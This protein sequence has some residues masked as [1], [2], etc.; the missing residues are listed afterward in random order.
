LHRK[1]Q[2]YSAIRIRFQVS[3]LSET[4]ILAAKDR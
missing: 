1:N 2:W 3:S 4:V